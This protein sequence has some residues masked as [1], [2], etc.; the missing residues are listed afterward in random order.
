MTG[1]GYVEVVE[2]N[3]YY[4]TVETVRFYRLQW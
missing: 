3:C 1:S 4:Q 2:K